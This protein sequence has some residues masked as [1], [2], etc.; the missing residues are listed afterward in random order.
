MWAAYIDGSLELRNVCVSLKLS[1]SIR[2]VA[3]D[4][5][6]AKL[7]KEGHLLAIKTF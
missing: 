1:G 7:A 5:S 2:E 4:E 6:K 3:E